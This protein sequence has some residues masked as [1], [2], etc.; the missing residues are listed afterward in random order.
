[1]NSVCSVYRSVLL[2]FDGSNY[3]LTVCCMYYC[4]LSIEISTMNL[5]HGMIEHHQRLILV[6][7]SRRC[8]P[9]R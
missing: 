2:N 9:W 1:M 4:V 7:I 5:G 6:A 3:H 8:R